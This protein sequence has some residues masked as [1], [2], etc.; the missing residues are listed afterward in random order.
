MTIDYNC[1]NKLF[2]KIYNNNELCE[3]LQNYVMKNKARISLDLYFCNKNRWE[4]FL[5]RKPFYKL[6]LVY[7]FLPTVKR[8]Y[9]YLGISEEIFFDTMDDIRIWI[10]DHKSRTGEY[11]LYELN[12][13]MH[14]MNLDIFKIGRLQFQKFKY[15]FNTSYKKD[16]TEFKFG[17]KILNIHIPRGERLNIDDCEK[18][19]STAKDFFEKHFPNY[20]SNKFICHSWL[21]YPQNKDFMKEN[22]NI[23]KFAKLFDIVKTTEHP[24]QTYLWIFGT[25]ENEKSLI[26][27]KKKFGKYGNTDNLPQKTSLQKSAVKYINN[28][29]TFG[30]G[31][32]VLMN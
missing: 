30:E 8:R 22:S 12:W 23:L 3:E 6:A 28:G 13:I 14:H 10:D 21:L 15:Y 16:D 17:E 24:T 7:S 2:L 4:F 31:M 25:K 5:K 9:D 18:S 26:E 19:I 1:S 11:G 27:N 20:P 29:G 32:G